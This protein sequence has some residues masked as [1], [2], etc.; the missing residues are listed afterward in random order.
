MLIK[1]RLHQGNMLPGNMLRVRATCC[2][3]QATCYCWQQHMLPVSRQHVSLC[4]QQQTVDKLSTI[5]LLATCCLLPETCCSSAQNAIKK[6]LK[7]TPHLK[8]VATL[9]C[10]VL[11]TCC[12]LQQATCCP[13]VNAALEIQFSGSSLK[14]C[15]K[16]Y[17]QHIQ[18]R[19]Q[20][21]RLVN[22]QYSDV[23][24]PLGIVIS[25]L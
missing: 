18:F 22:S 7:I 21:E 19:D 14:R 24:T 8:R 10:W 6:S 3:Q 25:W 15:C 23:H 5:L 20:L 11:A 17:W 1:P 9:P 2:R 4:I 13:G 16:K 12:L